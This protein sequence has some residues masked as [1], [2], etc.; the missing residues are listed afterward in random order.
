M[1][2]VVGSVLGGLGGLFGGLGISRAA[3]SVARTTDHL[4]DNVATEIREIR[5]LI[6]KRVIPALEGSLGKLNETL[7]H[8]DYVLGRVGHFVD[9]ATHSLSVHTNTIGVLIMLVCAILC[10]RLIRDIKASPLESL[11]LYTIYYACLLLVFYFGYEVLIQLGFLETGGKHRLIVIVFSFAMFEMILQAFWYAVE[12]VT[13]LFHLLLGCVSMVAEFLVIKPFVWFAT[14]FTR[15]KGYFGSTCGL[16][17]LL[18]TV[19]L[20]V[21]YAEMI[22]ELYLFATAILKEYGSRLHGPVWELETKFKIALILYVACTAASLLTHALFWCIISPVF[23][24]YWK[25]RRLQQIK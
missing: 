24:R 8:V 17:F 22:V 23:R 14:P 13:K 21:Y 6:E 16:A 1:W 20:G 12:H 11:I 25:F 19:I 5:R 7:A 10:R 2:G 4:A 9:T 18:Y 3:G 15:G